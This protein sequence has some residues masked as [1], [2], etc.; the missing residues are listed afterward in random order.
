MLEKPASS[1]SLAVLRDNGEWLTLVLNP[2]EPWPTILAS[3]KKQLS[4][5]FV[6]RDDQQVAVELGDRPVRKYELASLIALLNRRKL[7]LHTLH[8]S[9]P[10]SHQSAMAFSLNLECHSSDQDVV[11]RH[12]RFPGAQLPLIP[13]SVGQPALYLRGPL[14]DGR[15]VYSRA[16]LI[17]SGDVGR[18]TELLAVGD[19]L[20]WGRLCGRAH[21][22]IQGDQNATIG[23]FHWEAESL[24]I[25][26]HHIDLATLA[27]AT[28]AGIVGVK[29]GSSQWL[30]KLA[31]VGD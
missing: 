5:T 21:A 27:D 23:A 22:G 10:T 19:I 28:G 8:S 31:M 16:S 18:G 25:A 9:S 11:E 2:T 4:D 30:P 6:S 12:F 3:I 20:V 24:Q 7:K 1:E 14:V 15:C 17:V 26:N 29:N 13:E